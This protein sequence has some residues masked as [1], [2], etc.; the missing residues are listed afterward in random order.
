MRITFVL[1]HFDQRVS[2]GYRM[3]F[4]YAN[5]LAARGHVVTI[6]MFAPGLRSRGGR[7][8]ASPNALREIAKRWWYRGRIPWMRLD[9]RVDVIIR[10]R[11]DPALAPTGDVIIATA[12][13]T[14]RYVRDAP[15]RSG[16]KAYFIQH[17]E[18]WDGPR[19]DVDETWRF[20]LEKIVIARWLGDLARSLDPGSVARYVPNAIDHSVFRVVVPS[21][22]RAGDHVGMLWHPNPSK[23]ALDGLRA[24]SSVHAADPGV[25]VTLFGHPARPSEIPSWIDYRERLTG[26]DLV[27]YYN[28]LDVFLHT[29]TSEGWG[30]TPA[31]AMACGV[32]V[33]ATD[34]PG[35]L[36][37]AVAGET[38]VVVPRG[39]AFQMAQG[40]IDLLGDTQRRLTLAAAGRSMIE[41]FNWSRATESFERALS[42]ICGG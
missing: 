21:A 29:S 22:V 38:A 39:D 13:L 41:Q 1:P 8:Y 16:S 15:L 3:V 20:P 26:E 42:E 12:W 14:A 32:A 30:L 36:D 35:V 5:R 17:Y 33:V 11:D 19:A 24:L 9:E 18:I 34:N 4:E 2:G 25:R 7:R 6:I 40:I 37:Y 27:D 23:G 10:F 31:E 28:S